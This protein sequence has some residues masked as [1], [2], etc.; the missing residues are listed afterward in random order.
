MHDQGREEPK[1]VMYD[2]VR[3]NLVDHLYK[4]QYYVVHRSV[5]KIQNHAHAHIII[6]LK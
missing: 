4:L 6:I 2:I 3:L 5:S 1:S